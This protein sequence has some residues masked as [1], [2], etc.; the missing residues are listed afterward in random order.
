[1]AVAGVEGFDPVGPEKCPLHVQFLH[2]NMRLCLKAD[3]AETERLAGSG[4][5]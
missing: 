3:I 5:A 1:M 4:D 2:F